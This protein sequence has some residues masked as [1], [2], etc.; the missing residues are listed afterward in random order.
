MEPAV[1]S[2]KVENA[3]ASASRKRSSISEEG[4]KDTNCEFNQSSSFSYFRRKSSTLK[5]RKSTLIDSAAPLEMDE[6]LLHI[7]LSSAFSE[8]DDSDEHAN[9]QIDSFDENHDLSSIPCQS[10][11]RISIPWKSEQQ[12]PTQHFMS[13]TYSK[14]PRSHNKPEINSDHRTVQSSFDRRENDLSFHS[15]NSLLECRDDFE[16]PTS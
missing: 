4:T 7:H 13:N 9:K 8:D 10:Y 11:A 3:S 12:H 5:R 16:N 2:T 1:Q 15:Q 14:K 6:T